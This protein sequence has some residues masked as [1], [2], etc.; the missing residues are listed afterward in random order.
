MWDIAGRYTGNEL[1]GSSCRLLWS[2]GSLSR[3]Q[4]QKERDTIQGLISDISHQT[5]TPIANIRLYTELLKEMELPDEERM[6]VEALQKQREKL[7]LLIQNLIK[8]S[9]LETGMIRVTPASNEVDA[10]TKQVREQ[11]SPAAE[12]KG[13]CLTVQKSGARAMFDRVWTAEALYNL[14]DNAVKY[15]PRGGRVELE[16]EAFDLFCRINVR[17]SG[18]GIRETEQARIFTRFYRSE[19]A[20]ETEGTGVGLYL[21]REI[22][23]AQGGY[24]RVTSKPGEGSVF[25]VFLPMEAQGGFQPENT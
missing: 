18:M 4:I 22:I 12:G 9:R 20:A 10:L 14:V 8:M 5:K 7:Q 17:D 21:A 19:D 23:S 3:N 25:S 24:I 15:T 13:I 11:A 2:S 6:H 16:A 1:D